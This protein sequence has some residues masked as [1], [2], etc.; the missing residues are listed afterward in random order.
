MG[1][2]RAERF[3]GSRTHGRGKKAG[4][5]AGMRGGRGNAGLHKHRFMYL[6][7][8]DRDHFGRKGFKRH[9]TIVRDLKI[10]NLRT[11]QNILPVMVKEKAAKLKGDVYIVDLGRAGYDKL[12][13]KGSV[14]RKLFVKV[15]SATKNSIEKIEK[16]GGKVKLVA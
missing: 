1:S 8:N 4:R 11:L 10:I 16:A 12:L 6:L 14:D 13:S 9:R 7:K 15:G 2:K 5:G 3:K